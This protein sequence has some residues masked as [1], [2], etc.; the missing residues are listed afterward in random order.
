MEYPVWWIPSLS[1]AL[2]VAV[3]AIVHVFIAHF[4]IGGGLF[5]VLAERMGLK[6]PAPVSGQILAYVKRHTRFFLLLTLVAGGLTGV[7]IWFVIGAAS[8]AAT[9]ML[10]NTFVFGWATEWVFFVGEIVTLLVYYYTFGKMRSST[11]QTVGW[12]YFIFGWLSLFMINGIIGFMLTPGDWLQTRGFWDGFFN[13]TFWPSLVFRSMICFIIAGVFGYLTALRIPEPEARERMVRFSTWM[14]A[15]PFLPLVASAA[16]YVL[17]LPEPQAAMVL[18][19]SQEIPPFMSLFGVS[20]PLIFL[21]A[22]ALA[23]VTP[24][25]NRRFLAWLLLLLAFVQL[26]AFEWIREAGRRPYLIWETM[27]SNSILKAD[28]AELNEKGF[29]SRAK[30]VQHREI[31]DENRLQAGEELFRLQCSTCHSIGGAMLNILP[32]TERFTQFGMEAQLT[33]QGARSPYMPPF[34]GNAAEKQALA[35]YVVQELHGKNAAA[36]AFEPPQLETPELPWDEESEYLLV[37][38]STLGM[39]T[40]SDAGRFFSL[41]PPGNTFYAQL[42]RRGPLPELVTEDVELHYSLEQGFE[43]PADELRFWDFVKPTF[44]MKS[45]PNQGLTGNGP[46]GDMRLDKEMRAW[47]AE[48][49]PVSPYAW[50]GRVLPYPLLHV[51]AKDAETGE[52][53]AET[54]IVAPAS[55]E[56]GCMNCHGGGWSMPRG[57]PRMGLSEAT[58]TDI[59]RVHDKRSGTKLLQRAYSRNPQ[60]C[61]LCHQDNGMREVPGNKQQLSLSASIHG[62][63]AP[64]LEDLGEEA[65][66]ACHPGSPQGATRMLR[67]LHNDMMLVCTDCHGE[68]ADHSLALLKAEAEAGKSRADELMQGIEPKAVELE[69][70]APRQAWI[71]QPDC[72]SCHV[73]EEAGGEVQR[74]SSFNLWTEPGEK[75]LFRM[76]TDYQGAMMCTACHNSPHAV[77]PATN[78][79][80]AERDVLQ[81]LRYSGSDRALGSEQNCVP[82]HTMDMGFFPHHPSTQ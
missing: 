45:V 32:L 6:A 34:V 37:A 82:C 66:N 8:P 22:L 62:F 76:R 10:I 13:P 17:A 2:P 11:H 75:N 65:C 7:G 55:T 81:P 12:L 30:W 46:S 25:K 16:W 15:A 29:F 27:Y 79:Y 39:R 42:L 19:K 48:M 80:G 69:E 23:F 78:P 61:Q 14:A 20:T 44:H 49:V 51:E 59:L 50:D 64:Y 33:G 63:H 41:M 67:G 71:Q 18:S 9:N 21:G 58:A 56:M 28:V 24:Q 70:I 1:A 31:T 57:E 74:M 47:T 54:Q 43:E 26:G 53:L 40:F 68:M 60:P 35:A 5:L 77:Y 36:A 73:L 3:I 38:W 52:L 72:L 4:A